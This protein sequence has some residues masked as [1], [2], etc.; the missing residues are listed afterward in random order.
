MKVTNMK[1]ICIHLL[2]IIRTISIER[3]NR[4][5]NNRAILNFQLSV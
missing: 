2:E 5:E 1:E 4:N 3:D